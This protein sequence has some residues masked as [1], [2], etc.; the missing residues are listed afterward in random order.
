[1]E[2][3]KGSAVKSKNS[4]PYRNDPNLQVTASRYKQLLHSFHSNS[5]LHRFMNEMQIGELYTVNNNVYLNV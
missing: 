1:M 2:H 3:S 5:I 4:T